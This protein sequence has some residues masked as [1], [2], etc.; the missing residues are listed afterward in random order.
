MLFNHV[1]R[2]KVIAY[3]KSRMFKLSGS[4][5]LTLLLLHEI[6]LMKFVKNETK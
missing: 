6:V 4:L 2:V 5:Q 3:I 1:P